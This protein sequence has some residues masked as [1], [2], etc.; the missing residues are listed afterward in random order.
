MEHEASVTE[1]SEALVAATSG[2]TSK[3]RWVRRLAAARGVLSW[4]GG[5]ARPVGDMIEE[6]SATT[7]RVVGRGVTA[8]GAVIGAGVAGMGIVVGG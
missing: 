8:S 2:E 3:E 4:A 1:E 6:G 7:G 5:Q